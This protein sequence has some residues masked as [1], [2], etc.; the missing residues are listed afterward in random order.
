MPDPDAFLHA[1]AHDWRTADL[2]TADRALC[3]FAAPL[4]HAQHSMTTDGVDR[5]RAVGLSDAAIFD[6]GQVIGY[7]NYPTRVADALGVEPEDFAQPVGRRRPEGRQ[8]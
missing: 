5:L 3:A 8:G 7:C 2:G 1:V 6:A 4:T